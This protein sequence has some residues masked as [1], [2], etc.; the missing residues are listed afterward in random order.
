MTRDVLAW[1]KRDASTPPPLLKYRSS[2][3]FILSTI[4]I[5]VFTDMFLYG[6]IVPVI[7]FSLKTRLAIPQ[8]D[9][10]HWT[11]VLLAVYGA[12]LL[13]ASPI[14]GHLADHTP[15]R[16]LPLLIGLLALAGSTLLLCLGK[17]IA[18]LVV[19]RIL[20]GISAAIVWTVGLALLADTV[21]HE[22]IGQSM[23]YVTMMDRITNTPKRTL[24]RSIK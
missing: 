19:G 18:L 3:W 16:R 15:S 4:C 13:A 10:Q 11:S 24:A 20:Q 12:A 21:G 1:R 17:S 5:A 6:I 14:C 23:G 22:T 7:P 2:H 9:V 8:A